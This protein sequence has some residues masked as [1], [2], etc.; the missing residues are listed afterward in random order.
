MSLWPM[1]LIIYQLLS[2]FSGLTPR[3]GLP[4][5][6][7][8]D[9]NWKMIIFLCVARHSCFSPVLQHNCHV[10]QN[11]IVLPGVS[12]LHPGLFYTKP[13]YVGV[14]QEMSSMAK[15]DQSIK[16]KLNSPKSQIP[17]CL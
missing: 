13:M 5:F 12:T 6:S 15:Q 7:F 11:L 8:L 9:K 2:S 17:T 1:S 4:F 16:F 14:L 10:L 3:N